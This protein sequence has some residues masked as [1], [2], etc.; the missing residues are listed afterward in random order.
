MPK[1]PYKRKHG[2]HS[3]IISQAVDKHLKTEIRRYLTACRESLIRDLGPTEE[4]LSAAQL[5]LIDR[6]ISALGVVRAIEERVR[7]TGEILSEKGELLPALGK[8]YIAFQNSIRHALQAL[9]ISTKK[10]GG[11]LDLGTYLRE[12]EQ[13]AAAAGDPEAQDE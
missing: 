6:V 3:L 10:S 2:G 13:K 12:E 9:G 11:V 5:I 7:R 8:N 1:I 4:D